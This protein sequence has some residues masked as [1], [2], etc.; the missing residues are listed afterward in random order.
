METRFYGAVEAGGTKFV[1]AIGDASGKILQQTRYP[2]MD[3]I[4]TLS[5]VREF[6]REGRRTFGALSCRPHLARRRA[7]WAP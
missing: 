1:C 2:T 7:C 6:M 5:A 4:S 3:P